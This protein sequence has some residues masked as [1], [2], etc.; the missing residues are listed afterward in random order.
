[1]SFGRWIL[2]SVRDDGA[3]YLRAGRIAR[4]AWQAMEKH[5]LQTKVGRPVV[6]H[7]SLGRWKLG[8][9]AMQGFR[10]I[11]EYR[12]R[13][14]DER[15]TFDF[16]RMEWLYH[17]T[18]DDELDRLLNDPLERARAD[19]RGEIRDHGRAADAWRYAFTRSHAVTRLDDP[20]RPISRS[21]RTT[22]RTLTST[23][24]SS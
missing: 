10:P 12:L 18:S 7:R 9:L 13:E 3:L 6:D 4:R 15:I 2:G 8:V 21:G 14:P 5:V 20:M 11:A 24:S 22:V 17:H 16:R 19:A 23:G 1:M